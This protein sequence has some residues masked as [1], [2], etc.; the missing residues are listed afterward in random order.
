MPTSPGQLLSQ[1]EFTRYGSVPWGTSP[2]TDKPGVYVVSLHAHP[3]TVTGIA[4]A[5]IDE[6]AVAAWIRRVQSLTLDSARPQP[7]VLGDRLACYWL[8][9]E[10]IV[11]VGKATSL[12]QRLR[13]YYS[14]P[15]GD[16]RPHAGGHWIKTLANLRFLTVH[17]A[18]ISGG[19]DPED[20][21]R[22]MLTTFARNVSHATRAAHPQ[23]DLT[24]PFAN[25][26]IKGLGRR[27]HG[28]RNAVL[29]N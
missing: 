13:Q 7:S 21:E 11:Y 12:R 22:G 27:N 19:I 17:Y 16:R 26:E 14:T 3:Y 20:V 29:R 23:P 2:P 6:A 24:V 25:L 9:D 28:I 10:A 18:E 8:P 4:Q 1:V 15:L 5:P